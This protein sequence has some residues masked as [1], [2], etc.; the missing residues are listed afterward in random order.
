MWHRLC[1]IMLYF[2]IIMASSKSDELKKR[3]VAEILEETKRASARAEVRYIV[4]FY[5]LLDPSSKDRRFLG[6]EKTQTG[7]N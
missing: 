5:P 7:E 6:L 1:N 2:R 3:A 4:F